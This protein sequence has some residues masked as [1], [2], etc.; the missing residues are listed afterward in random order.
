MKI[1]ESRVP[2]SVPPSGGAP[3]PV[4]AA[5]AAE[6]VTTGDAEHLRQTIDGGVSMAAGE[7]SRRLES[8]TQQVRAG[9]Y[10]PN[11]S[12]LAEEI[13]AQADLDTRLAQSFHQK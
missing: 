13:L 11:I 7:R 12:Q 9:V 2:V 5:Q 1:G 10:R 4:V 6:R 3:V 8:L